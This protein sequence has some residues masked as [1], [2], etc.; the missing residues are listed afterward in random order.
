ML[1]VDMRAMSKAKMG[2]KVVDASG[3]HQ[4]GEHL[5]GSIP[6]GDYDEL[7]DLEEEAMEMD[8]LT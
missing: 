5:L 2:Y 7:F 8:S 3:S 1:G 6:G 4:N